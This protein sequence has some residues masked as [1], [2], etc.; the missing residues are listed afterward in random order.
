L[1]LEVNNPSRLV[2]GPP[3][4]K[5]EW[6]PELYAGYKAGGARRPPHTLIYPSLY[7]ALYLWIC[8]FAL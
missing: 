4:F 2:R 8:K 7:V 6:K 5:I 1:H 3:S